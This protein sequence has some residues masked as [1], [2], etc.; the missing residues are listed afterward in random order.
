MNVCLDKKY[1]SVCLMWKSDFWGSGEK[2]TK[3]K[4]EWRLFTELY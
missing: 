4:Q 2:K 3:W 1:F